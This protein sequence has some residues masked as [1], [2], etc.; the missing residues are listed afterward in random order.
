MESKLHQHLSVKPRKN[1]GRA[2]G[3]RCDLPSIL[4]LEMMRNSDHS[5]RLGIA[6]I[7]IIVC[8]PK[9][10]AE[11]ASRERAAQ[12][13]DAAFSAHG[14]LDALEHLQSLTVVA[15]GTIDQSAELQGLGPG[16]ACIRSF[17]ERLYYEASSASVARQVRAPRNDLSLRWRKTVL[18]GDERLFVD[19]VSRRARRTVDRDVP[20]ERRGLLRRFPHFALR[21]ARESLDTLRSVGTVEL[22]G[23]PHHVIAYRPLLSDADDEL[24]LFIDSE[25]GAVAK[26][27]MKLDFPGL[28]ETA[29]E[30]IF[31]DHRRLELLGLFPN[32]HTIQVA[33]KPYVSVFYDE[34]TVNETLPEE[35][36]GL[37]S[38]IE[39]PPPPRRTA[40]PNASSRL[41]P[42]VEEIAEG[43]FFVQNLSG[44]NTMFVELEDFVL[45]VEAPADHPWLEYVPPT[46]RSPAS[47]IGEEF[48]DI[49]KRRIPEKPIR[50]LALTHHHSDHIGGAR[51]FMAEGTTLLTT[52]GNRAL[53]KRM[54]DATYEWA[55]DRLS[56]RFRSPIIETFEGKRL[57]S[58]GKKTVELID[59]GANPHT[60]EMTIVWIPEEKILFQGD[61]FYP[62]PLD[63]FP[64]PG[65]QIIMRYF[66]QWLEENRISPER[67]YG[68]HGPWYG[69]QEHI[70][71]IVSGS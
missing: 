67:I 28:G 60:E 51:A 19:F 27:Q 35:A 9:T 17:E 21:E 3:T 26:Y 71:K 37:P 29:L 5:T 56:R 66:V 47:S 52:A 44:F 41:S 55:P 32:G 43:V 49:I 45:A 11:T 31:H 54:G 33:G 62:I 12:V 69:T 50:Y 15:R 14:G 4:F 46:N 39:A 65:R 61:L 13:L 1:L 7:A 40:E 24:S 58:D 64:P 18:T 63:Y 59:I 2:P 34:V 20:M 48:V 16:K 6:V 53:L 42:K 70:E 36:L 68:V 8:I 57:V 30:W 23:R 10:Y 25:T 38:D 22:E